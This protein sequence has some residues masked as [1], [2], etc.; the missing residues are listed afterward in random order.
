MGCTG[1]SLLSINSSKVSQGKIIKFHALGKRITIA[2][3]GWTLD[4]KGNI[5]IYI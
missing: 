1:R 4:L 2:D 5:Y 3:T